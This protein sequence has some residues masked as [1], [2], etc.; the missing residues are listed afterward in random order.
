MTQSMLK[1]VLTV[2]QLIALNM[3]HSLNFG[4]V[5]LGN[6]RHNHNLPALQ[7]GRVGIAQT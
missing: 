1:H 6:M 7:R 2:I 3:K 5:L 4:R